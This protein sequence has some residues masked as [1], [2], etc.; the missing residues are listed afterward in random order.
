MGRVVGASLYVATTLDEEG[1]RTLA[2]VSLYPSET[3]EAWRKF[4]TVIKGRGIT[5]VIVAVSDAN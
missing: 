2:G 3:Y 1:R 4:L 5:G